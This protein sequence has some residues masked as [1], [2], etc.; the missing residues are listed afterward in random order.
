[1][2]TDHSIL[3]DALSEELQA[4]Y[5]DMGFDSRDS[6]PRTE[7]TGVKAHIQVYL[8]IFVSILWVGTLE[9]Q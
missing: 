4:H 2:N 3:G 5:K 9:Y 7:D 1:M 6:A 8:Y